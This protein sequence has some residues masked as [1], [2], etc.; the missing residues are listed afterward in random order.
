MQWSAYENPPQSGIYATS[1]LPYQCSPTTPIPCSADGSLDGIISYGEDSK[2]DIYLL[3]VNGAYRMVSPSQC[4]ITCTAVLPEGP[5]PAPA[6][7]PQAPPPPSDASS[8]FVI[9][10]NSAFCLV[11]ALCALVWL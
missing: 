8:L 2:G 9:L 10:R 7:E 4:G 11:L 1:D 3:A 5:A 6:P